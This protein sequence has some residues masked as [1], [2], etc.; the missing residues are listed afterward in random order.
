MSRPLLITDCDEVLLHM[1][2]PYRAWLEEVHHVHFDFAAGDFAEALRHKDTGALIAPGLV[3]QLLSGFFATEMHR[4]YPIAGAVDALQRLSRQADVVILTN[5]GADGHAGRVTQLR[6]VGIDFP[7]VCNQGGK[8]KPLSVIVAERKPSVT[9]FVDDLAP[10]HESV[11]QHA[12][13]VWR[14]HMVGEPELAGHIPDAP[15]AHARID[16]WAAAEAW[17]AARFAE[18]MAA[19][20]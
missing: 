4:Q 12:P 20:A 6:E 7:V 13:D 18:G 5:I 2:V 19:A 15:H 10:H 17:I 14:L 16:N 1:V 3:W 11:A 9:V 8:G